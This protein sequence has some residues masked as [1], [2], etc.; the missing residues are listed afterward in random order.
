QDSRG[1]AVN[2]IIQFTSGLP[3]SVSQN[4]DSQNT[5]SASSP[6]PNVVV[7]AVVPRVAADRN[8]NHWFDMNAFVRSK[9]DG[10]TGVGLFLPGTLGY[11]NAG[12]GLFDAPAQKPWDFGLFKDFQ[13]REGERLQTRADSC[14]LPN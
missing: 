14:N 10:C 2:G 3:V 9:C 4:G 13:S 11:G 1:W 7:G 12:V 5:G 8:L 6:R